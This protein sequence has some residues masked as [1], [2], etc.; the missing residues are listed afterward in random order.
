MKMKKMSDEDRILIESI[1]EGSQEEFNEM[2]A[3]MTEEELFIVLDLIRLAKSELIEEQL[4]SIET[5]D[6]SEASNVLHNIMN[7]PLTRLKQLGIKK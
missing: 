4:D 5:L 1:I 2:M 6:Y 3:E 7:A